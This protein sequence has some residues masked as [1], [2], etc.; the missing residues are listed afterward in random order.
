M[1]KRN[2]YVSYQSVIA[3]ILYGGLEKMK[4]CIFNRCDS[5]NLTFL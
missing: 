5:I 1:K 3:E 4:E 2:R